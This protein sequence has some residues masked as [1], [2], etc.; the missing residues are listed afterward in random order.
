MSLGVIAIIVIGYYIYLLFIPI[1]ILFSIFFCSLYQIKR[2]I[3][4]GKFKFK[5]K[6]QRNGYGSLYNSLYINDNKSLVK[7]ETFHLTGI[8]KLANEM[9]FYKFIIMNDIKINIPKIFYYST[10]FYIMNYI[11]HRKIVADDYN[12]I[13]MELKKLHSF[14]SIDVN[15]DYYKQLLFEETI[16]KIKDRYK[17]IAEI[18][19]DFNKKNKITHINNIK[20]LSF[21]KIIELLENSLINHVDNLNK[22]QLQVIH[23]DPQFNNICINEEKEIIFIDP[24]GC[25]GSSKIYGIKEYDIAKVFFAMSGYSYFDDLNIQN[26][27]IQNLDNINFIKIPDFTIFNDYDISLIILLFISIWLSNPHAFINDPI[28]MIYSYYI[29]LYISSCLLSVYNH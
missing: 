18:I 12:D 27:N 2:F 22:Y 5:T 3:Y 21:N 4:N 19:E 1:T 16:I 23:G 10:N 8:K 15:K 20:I 29:S 7:K 9:N 14:K 28:K 11:N 6:I 25:F 24:K 17:E 26:L 13:I